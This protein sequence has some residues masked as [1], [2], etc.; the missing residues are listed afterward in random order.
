MNV[1]RSMLSERQVPKTFWS[2]AVRWSVHIQNRSPT[3]AL[4]NTTPE[5]AWNGTKP[6]VDYF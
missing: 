4:E 5:E 3:V 2:E 1:V 6:V